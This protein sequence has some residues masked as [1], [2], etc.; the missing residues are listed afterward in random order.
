MLDRWITSFFLYTKAYITHLAY[1][2]FMKGQVPY[3][4]LELTGWR[5]P[6]QVD[7]C[8]KPAFFE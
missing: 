8:R 4:S 1:P 5:R 7:A 2:Q 6:V 3:P